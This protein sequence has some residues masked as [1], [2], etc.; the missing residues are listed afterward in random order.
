MSFLPSNDV[1]IYPCAYRDGSVDKK[2]RLNLEENIVALGA[3]GLG[4]DK[5]GSYIITADLT[6]DQDNKWRIKA[7]IGG[8]YVEI[9]TAAANIN[10]GDYLIIKTDLVGDVRVLAPLD[11]VTTVGNCLDVG[12]NFVGLLV[13]NELPTAGTNEIIYNVKITDNEDGDDFSDRLPDIKAGIGKHAIALGEGTIAAGENQFVFGKYNVSASSTY[14]EIVGA[15][16]ST[17]ALNIRT[18]D[19]EGNEILASSLSVPTIYASDITSNNQLNITASTISLS[20][21]ISMSGDI[22]PTPTNTYDLG[23]SSNV[24]DSIYGNGIYT[25]SIYPQNSST[26]LLKLDSKTITTY[27]KIIPNSDN[28]LSIGTS[29]LRFSEANIEN[30]YGSMFMSGTGALS[31]F[32]S[33][34]IDIAAFNTLS[35]NI[36]SLNS[37][38][39]ILGNVA[40]SSSALSITTSYIFINFPSGRPGYAPIQV[41][42]QGDGPVDLGSTTNSF[43]YI[44]TQNISALSTYTQNISASNAYFKDIKGYANG[45]LNISC[46]SGIYLST[47]GANRSIS[48]SASNI[49]LSA[50]AL[51]TS[52]THY[53]IS[54]NDYINFD[55]Y[56][57]SSIA[58]ELAL[59]SGGTI[60]MSA[61][62]LTVEAPI[63]HIKFG[64]GGKG[65]AS[66]PIYI[67]TNGKVQECSEI[68][69]GGGTLSNSDGIKIYVGNPDVSDAGSSGGYP[70]SDML[71]SG[72][73][74]SYFKWTWIKLG[75]VLKISIDAKTDKD[76]NKTFIQDTWHGYKIEEL[77]KASVG[78]G[79]SYGGVATITGS[80]KKT[81]HA[82]SFG[83]IVDTWVDDS[84]VYFGNDANNSGSA[85]Y[86]YSIEITILLNK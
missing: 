73:G 21:N 23:N 82:N 68:K 86:G 56:N 34:D 30:I 18:L 71:T 47:S 27:G 14:A 72:K 15:G 40:L 54:T 8:Y 64:N 48:L 25:T 67:D 16:T 5:S 62:Y 55:L 26:Q 66:K 44:Y 7:V 84:F 63:S 52:G 1:R 59:Y 79:Y 57:G 43:N 78:S 41:L 50:Y 45:V 31:L 12:G 75:K 3:N 4:K 36:I 70:I 42:P 65:N 53:N 49:Y 37:E 28:S 17:S 77:I 11:G 24:W 19:W 74:W 35:F 76:N 32:A 38:V 51:N 20:G 61:D 13:A 2:S 60:F 39:N 83:T 85:S 46:T 80:T 69:S 33:T 10:A 81:N 58:A 6:A 29:S 22:I 9:N